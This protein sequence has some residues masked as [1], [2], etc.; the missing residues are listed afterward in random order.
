[1]GD[2]DIT[3]LLSFLTYLLIVTTIVTFAVA[4]FVRKRFVRILISIFLFTMAATCVLFSMMAVLLVASLGAVTMVLAVKTPVG[5][6]SKQTR[7]RSK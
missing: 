4:M 3:V 6:A 1:M 7:S 2:S 5:I